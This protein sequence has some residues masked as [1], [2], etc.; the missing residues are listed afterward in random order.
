MEKSGVKERRE[1]P[2]YACTVCQTS[3][4]FAS[5]FVGNHVVFFGFF[6]HASEHKNR[7]TIDTF[8]NEYIAR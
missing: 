8:S 5:F 3:Q 1:H 2:F 6:E 4:I 7:P